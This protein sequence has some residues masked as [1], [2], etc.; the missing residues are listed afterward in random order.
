MRPESHGPKKIPPVEK[1][2]DTESSTFWCSHQKTCVVIHHLQ[3]Y[4][5]RIPTDHRFPLPHT[6]CHSQSESLTYGFL[7]D[8]GG[9]TL[10]SVDG[11]VR[12]RRKQVYVDVRIIACCHPDLIQHQLTFRVVRGTTPH[13]HQLQRSELLDQS[14]GFNDTQRI[15]ESVKPGDLNNQR[16][17]RV[18][19]ESTPSVLNLFMRQVDILLAERVDTGRNQ[20]LRMRQRQIHLPRLRGT[21]L[22]KAAGWGSC[23]KT[24]SASSSGS[25]SQSA[26]SAL[27]LSYA[28]RAPSDMSTACP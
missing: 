10:D 6:L 22:S 9:G 25:L 24:K 18:Q 7:Q 8:D 27:V 14:I 4:P 23:M 16:Q 12:I 5:S 17:L 3:P 2:A 21:Y 28:R 19:V 11:P 1:I 15:L 20:I 13:Q 26:F